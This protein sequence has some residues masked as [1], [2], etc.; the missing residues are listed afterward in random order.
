MKL[1]ASERVSVKKSDVKQIRREGKI[2]AILYS[3]GQTNQQLILDGSEFGAI[4]RQMPPGHLPTTIFTLS[5]NEKERKA[6]IKDI[7]YHLTTY[8]VSHVDFEELVEN[9]P[10]SIKVPI[11]CVGVAEC[12]G[13]K[14][15]GYLRQV[16]RHV[17]VEC[18]P[19]HIP[20]EFTVDVKDLGIKQ[21]KR[22]ADISM[23]KGVRPLAQMDEVVVVIAKRTT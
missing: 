11:Q 9:V 13:V 17:Q 8:Q 4:L 1:T 10:I 2:P 19:K 18:L 23:P 22:L 20:T 21:S 7:Q 5:I 14:L 12:V 16:R 15:G 3:P 6:I